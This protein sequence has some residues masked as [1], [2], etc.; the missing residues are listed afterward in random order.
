[1]QEYV[2]RHAELVGEAET[3]GLVEPLD[4]RRFERAAGEI[5]GIELGKIGKRHRRG[6]R[7]RVERQ[8]LHGLRAA[9]RA[10]GLNADA[11]AIGDGILAI[12]PQ[13]VG[14][15][16]NVGAACVGHDEAE[17]LGRIEPLHVTIEFE[18]VFSLLVQHFVHFR[19]QR[20]S[21]QPIIF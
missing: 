21:A 15:Q 6:G 10:L 1:M 2:V 8:D 5:L 11:G 4:P 7:R 3:L 14:V 17:P 13:H 12:V 19:L 18:A 20:P 16:K 9:P